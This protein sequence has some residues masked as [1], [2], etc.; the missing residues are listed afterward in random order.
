M[1]LKN[2]KALSEI[3]SF[4]LIT[5]IVSVIATASYLISQNILSNN[6]DVFERDKME[7]SLKKIFLKIKEIE[8]FDGAV[9]SYVISFKSGNLIFQDNQLLYYSKVK[10]DGSDICVNNLCYFNTNGFE[11]I[12]FNL[13]S[14]YNFSPNLILPP[15]TYILI[16][17]N[18][19]NESKIQISLK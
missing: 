9:S 15:D 3:V 8:N 19:K 11:I 17:E 6:V 12:Y 5:L 18:I 2:K 16:F 10:Y 14:S 4:L 7:N 1:L 13:S